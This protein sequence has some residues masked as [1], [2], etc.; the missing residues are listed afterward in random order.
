MKQCYN[1]SVLCGNCDKMV[2]ISIVKGVRVEDD[3]AKHP[4]PNCGCTMEREITNDCCDDDC[5]DCIDTDKF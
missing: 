4:C 5:N 1:V 3:L 2:T